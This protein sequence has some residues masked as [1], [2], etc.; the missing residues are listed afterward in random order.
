M[1]LVTSSQGIPSGEGTVT[2][3]VKNYQKKKGQLF[4]WEENGKRGFWGIRD[5]QIL[6]DETFFNISGNIISLFI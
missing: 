5:L 4:V 2:S 1:S 6:P 3:S